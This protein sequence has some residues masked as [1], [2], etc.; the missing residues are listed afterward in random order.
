MKVHVTAERCVGHGM[1][2]LACPEVFALNDDDGLAIVLM[3]TVPPESWPGV[4]LAL[5]GCPEHA[6]VV[7]A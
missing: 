2:Q 6:V 5:R 3:E 4:D 7:E 1:C